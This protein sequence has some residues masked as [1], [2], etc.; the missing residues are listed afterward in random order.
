MTWT[1]KRVLVT[2]AETNTGFAIARHFARAGA[3]VFLHAP[4]LAKA[5]AAAGQLRPAA[6]GGV[7]PVAAD[8]RRPREI[9]RMIAAVKKHGGGLDVLVNNAV[10]Q[11][12]G[13]AMQDTPR[14]LLRDALAVNLEG[15]FICTQLVVRAMLRQGG[16][17]IVN[18]GS[19]TAERAI[20]HRTVYIA[21]KGGLE[22]LTRAL[23]VEL[24]GRG[25]RVNLVV[26]GYIHSDRWAAL[27][28]RQVA[29]R[30]ANVPSG[31]EASADDVADAV[32][33]L[34]SDTARSITGARLAVDGGVLAQ[35][36]PADVEA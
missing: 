20:R 10:M 3:T 9:E 27:P 6:P 14:R 11:A 21:T 16:G 34:A 17:V 30:R 8:F 19:N 5:R 22:A 23:A 26:P 28:K 1:K 7:F 25:I 13:Y 12:V 24:A 2:G 31:H 4:T 33:F 36:L 35:M 29:R 18:I 15:L 32:L